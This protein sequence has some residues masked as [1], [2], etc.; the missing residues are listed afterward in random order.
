MANQI[1]PL[2]YAN[3]FG[4][5]VTTTNNVLAETNNLGANNYTK[6]TGT[7]LINSPG[8]GLQVANDAIV[9]GSFQVTGTGS[10]ATIQNNLTSSLGT[11]RAANNIGLGLRIDGVA[12][13]ANLQII[14]TGLNNAGGPSL[15]VANN[16][17]L[18]GNTTIA[19]NLVVGSNTRVANL[20]SNT[21]IISPLAHHVTTYST[22]F[23]ANG[24]VK[25]ISVKL[26]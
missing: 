8:T 21:W 15:Y 22:T 9:Q 16:S 13:I 3:T 11:I 2:S 19:N 14:G 17:I 4:D 12:N 1:T 18:N 20:A 23:F 26:V 24:A 5:W 25:I 7:L 10:S 6:D